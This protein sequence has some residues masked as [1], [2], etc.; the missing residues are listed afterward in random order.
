MSNESSNE[1]GQR[2]SKFKMVDVV[3]LGVSTDCEFGGSLRNV[4]LFVEFISIDEQVER[5]KL[6]KGR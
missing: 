5:L 3:K 1:S 6:F 2:F 4:F